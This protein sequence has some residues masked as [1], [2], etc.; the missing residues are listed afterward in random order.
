MGRSLS[1]RIRRAQVKIDTL[2]KEKARLDKVISVAHAQILNGAQKRD[3]ANIEISELTA[4]LEKREA[5]GLKLS[6]TP[7]DKKSSGRLIRLRQSLNCAC[8]E[9]DL[10]RPEWIKRMVDSD[11]RFTNNDVLLEKYVLSDDGIAPT[12]DREQ[13]MAIAKSVASMMAGIKAPSVKSE[14]MLDIKPGWLE[15]AA[16]ELASQ[17]RAEAGLSAELA[18]QVPATA[19]TMTNAR[20][21]SADGARHPSGISS[22]ER[23]RRRFVTPEPAPK[24]PAHRG[25][26]TGDNPGLPDAVLL[27]LG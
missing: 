15:S 9:A 11:V 22:L 7:M 25:L 19:S 10:P 8:D 18:I 23:G 13:R 20:M 14:N 16:L 21:R 6:K 3:L 27:S 17:F 4:R 24:R 2:D 1:E 5:D 12:L 26:A